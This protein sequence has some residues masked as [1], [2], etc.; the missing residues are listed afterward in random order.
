MAGAVD[1]SPPAEP[2]HLSAMPMA[3][4]GVAAGA[5]ALALLLLLGLAVDHWPFAWDRAILTG[6]RTHAQSQG[7]RAAAVDFTALGSVPVLVLMVAGAAILLLARGWWLLALATVAFT[8]LF[9][10][11][12][13]G[14]LGQLAVLFGLLAGAAVAAFAG[15]MSFDSVWSG[16]VL[17]VPSL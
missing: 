5:L 17:S 10:R 11:L 13:H 15:L 3:L 16:D 7:L 2:P 14:L 1:D 9:A 12:F 6:L 4:R 8:L